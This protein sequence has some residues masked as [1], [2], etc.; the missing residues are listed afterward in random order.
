VNYADFEVPFTR[1]HEFG[2]FHPERNGPSDR[3]IIMR[4]YSRATLADD[5]PHYPVNTPDDRRKLTASC[6][7]AE[8]ERGVIFGGRLGRHQYVDTAIAATLTTYESELQ[9]AL[10]RLR[11]GLS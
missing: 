7:L 4:E 2:H 5:E 6:V 9:P 11:V 1:I 3:T 10:A 8:A